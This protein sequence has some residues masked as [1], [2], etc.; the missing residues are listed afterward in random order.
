M[1]YASMVVV[2]VFSLLLLTCLTG[3]SMLSFL[4]QERAQIESWFTYPLALN[5]LYTFQ[6]ERVADFAESLVSAGLQ[7]PLEYITREQALDREIQRNP[8]ILAVLEW[9]NPLPDVILIPLQGIDTAL[10]WQRIQEFRDLFDSGVDSTNIRMR[11][12][13][14]EQSMQDIRDIWVALLVFTG[15]TLLL[16]CML[17]VAILRYHL[18][19]FYS[20][21]VVGRLVWADPVFI[22]WPHIVTGIL[23]IVVSI[24]LALWLFQLLHYLF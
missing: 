2:F 16:M 12:E 9:D 1:P 23:Y 4:T 6:S 20:E 10:L 7:K 11:L 3:L 17:L 21:R 14:F 24:A 18:R 15:L 8:G 13:K 5:P 19:L 22:W